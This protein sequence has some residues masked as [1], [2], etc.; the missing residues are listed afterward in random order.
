MLISLKKKSPR[1]R[2]S[3][4]K[5]MLLSYKTSRIG[6]SL[7]KNRRE[8]KSSMLEEAV[9]STRSLRIRMAMN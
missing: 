2:K 3:L 5:L 1:S 8:S 7:S 4:S 6:N 9:R